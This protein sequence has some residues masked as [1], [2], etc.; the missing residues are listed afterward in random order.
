M[1]KV[2]SKWEHN[3]IITQIHGDVHAVLKIQA[4]SVQTAV[5][6]NPHRQAHGDV[7]AVLKIQVNSVQSAE[8]QNR[9]IQVH[10]DVHAVLKIKVNSV[11]I[12]ENR[13]QKQKYINVINAAGNRQTLQ[14]Y[15]D[16]ALN[17]VTR[18]TITTF[19][20]KDTVQYFLYCTVFYN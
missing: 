19:Y 5:N 8:N 1:H 4:N 20:N 11:Q 14:I 18:S 13:N 10:G 12:A 6:P 3:S 17:A 7:H 2:F 15:R 16:S 9:Q